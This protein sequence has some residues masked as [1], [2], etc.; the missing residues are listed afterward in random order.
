MKCKKKCLQILENPSYDPELYQNFVPQ[1]AVQQYVSSY[2][3]PYPPNYAAG[4]IPYGGPGGYPNP[5]GF[6]IQTGYEGFLVPSIPPPPPPG[7][8]FFEFFAQI[9]PFPRTMSSMFMKSGSYLLSALVTLLMG[10][11]ATTAICTMTPLCSITFAA[12][13][14][15]GLRGTVEKVGAELT[16]DRVKRAAEFVKTALEK[17]QKMQKDIKGTKVE[18]ARELIADKSSTS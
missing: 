1:D 18:T 11:L 2:G 9:L 17:Y 14:L 13:P 12:L 7:P 5:A 10:G 4:G 6:A 16:T 8:G 15:I 3:G